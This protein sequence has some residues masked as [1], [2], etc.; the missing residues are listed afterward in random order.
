MDVKA[1]DLDWQMEGFQ[2]NKLPAVATGYLF[3]YNCLQFK[4][5]LMKENEV[6]RN[7]NS[8]K[9]NEGEST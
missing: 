5:S 6:R 7:G 9:I 4:N 8:V 3:A 2:L 1:A